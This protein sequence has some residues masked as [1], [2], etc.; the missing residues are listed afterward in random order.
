MDGQPR[1][2]F[3]FQL[4]EEQRVNLKVFFI[5]C[6]YICAIFTLLAVY[7]PL[8]S[9]KDKS[10]HSCNSHTRPPAAATCSAVLIFIVSFLLL[11]YALRPIELFVLCLFVSLGKSDAP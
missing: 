10:F 4:R 3:D 11:F 6:K 9:A 7:S 2:A 5:R 1:I 8:R